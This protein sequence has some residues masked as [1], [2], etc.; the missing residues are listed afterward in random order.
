MKKDFLVTVSSAHDNLTGVDF[1]CSFFKPLSEH[2]IT[3]LHICRLD[4]KTCSNAL[5]EMWENPDDI[6]KGKPNMFAKKALEKAQIKLKESQMSVGEMIV[7]TVPERY[8][9]I[10]DILN[11]GSSGLYD[12]IILGKRASYTLQWMFERPADETAKAIVKDHSVTTPVWI[13]PEK[14]HGLKNVVVGVDGS[15]WSLRAVD[16]VGYILANQEQHNI[17]LLH[18][19][20]GAG[21]D[22]DN[23]FSKAIDI[24]KEN[25]IEPSRISTEKIWGLNVATTILSFAEK[26]KFAAIAVGLR[27]VDE[28]IMKRFNLA[29]DT[30]TNLIEKTKNI[31][32]WCCP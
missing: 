16:H 14:E 7:K 20:N 12:A 19:K 23:I 3:I 9:K 6:V 8:G 27:G 22:P 13:C 28:G 30:T 26:G 17:T 11:E 31:S 15:E 21:L 18:V 25:G 4:A 29:G 1:V 10:K 5:L 32:L 2:N 24:L